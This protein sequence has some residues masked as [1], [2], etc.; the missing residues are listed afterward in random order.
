MEDKEVKNQEW[1]LVKGNVVEQPFSSN[2]PVFG[3]LIVWFRS[4]WNSVATRWYVRPMVDQ[5]NEYNRQLVERLRDFESYTYE[6]SAEQDRDLSRLRHDV[7]ALHVQLM[8]LNG[9]LDELNGLL[10]DGNVDGENSGEGTGA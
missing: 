4:R 5:Q 9:R 10:Q 3:P 6:L 7:A 8:Q 1:L 2:V